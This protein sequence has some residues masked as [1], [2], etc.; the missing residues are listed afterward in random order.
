VYGRASVEFVPLPV[1]II[2]AQEVKLEIFFLDEHHD[3]M[4]GW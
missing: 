4:D 2:P 1:S 3:G